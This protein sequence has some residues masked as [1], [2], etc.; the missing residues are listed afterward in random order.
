MVSQMT[1]VCQSTPRTKLQAN[2]C[3]ER[4]VQLRVLCGIAQLGCLIFAGWVLWVVRETLTRCYV[5]VVAEIEMHGNVSEFVYKEPRT[6]VRTDLQLIGDLRVHRP[7][8]LTASTGNAC[9]SRVKAHLSC[10]TRVAHGAR[11]FCDHACAATRQPF[12]IGGSS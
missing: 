8:K 7:P 9:A 5:S 12:T 10:H 11:V 3:V 2:R 4:H 1:R 6:C